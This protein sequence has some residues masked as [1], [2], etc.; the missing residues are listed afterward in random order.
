MA[1]R[2]ALRETTAQR[3]LAFEE[4]LAKRL[5]GPAPLTK[6]PGAFWLTALVGKRL[7]EALQSTGLAAD[8]VTGWL[9]AVRPIAGLA[10][11]GDHDLWPYFARRFGIVPVAFLEPKPGIQPSS[12]HLTELAEKMRQEHWRVI[13]SAAFFPAS[14]ARL[15]AEKTGAKIA[16]MAHQTGSRPP[17]TSYLEMVDYNVTALLDAAQP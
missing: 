10:V 17:C 14:H 9:G 13:L 16:N 12:R 15:V 8:Q 5:L 7:A 6:Q 4:Q 1:L 2:P 3:V 11:V